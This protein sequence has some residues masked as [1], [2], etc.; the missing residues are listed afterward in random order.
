[1]LVIPLPPPKKVI[2][3]S[4]VKTILMAL[5]Q[6]FSQDILRN[7]SERIEELENVKR[8]FAWIMFRQIFASANLCC[9]ISQ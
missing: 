1:M 9:A 7:L 6:S 4:Q 2:I 8:P 3:F 5:K